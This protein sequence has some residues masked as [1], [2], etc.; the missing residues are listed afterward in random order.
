MLFSDERD[1]LHGKNCVHLESISNS[2]G[3][4]LKGLHCD[5]NS[6]HVLQ[7]E[8]CIVNAVLYYVSALFS[9]NDVCKLRRVVL[10]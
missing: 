10:R 1:N 3:F 8:E 4:R 5:C 6:V 9:S 2:K 7:V